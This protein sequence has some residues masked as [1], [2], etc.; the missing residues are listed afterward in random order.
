MAYEPGVP[1]LAGV[2]EERRLTTGQSPP[3]PPP[4]LRAP[5]AIRVEEVRKSFARYPA[6]NDVSL[7]VRPGE[8]LALLGPSGSGKTTLLRLIAGLDFPE[9]GAIRFDGDDVTFAAAA[10]RE[11]VIQLLTH[12][13]RSPQSSILAVIDTA[14]PGALAPEVAGKLSGYARRTLALADNFVHLA[15]AESG[16]LTEEL[17]DL[18]DIATEACDDLWPLAQKAGVTLIIE[19]ADDEQLV[20]GDRSLLSRA[21]LNLLDNAVK[22]S[23]AD[24]TVTAALARITPDGRAMATLSITDQGAGLTAEQ[25]A[26]LFQRFR[27]APGASAPGIGL[28]LTLVDEVAR[29]HGGAVAVVSEPG[30]GATF[31]LTFPLAP[32]SPAEGES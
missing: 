29:R 20:R 8:L 2:S 10:Q 13:I 32:D 11:Q 26:G 22:Y 4:P 14:G 7:D 27:R 19:G 9:A 3:P 6:L 5:L 30:G 17:L 12:D 31:V 28:G 16:V 15:K 23:P 25:Q 21:V 24:G 18:A 1:T